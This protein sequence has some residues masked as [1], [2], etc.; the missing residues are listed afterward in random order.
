MQ[1]SDIP[2]EQIISHSSYVSALAS[3]SRT[4]SLLSSS[5][6]HR[7]PSHL[8][9]HLDAPPLVP[10]RRP[11]L[12]PAS[13]RRPVVGCCAP[14]VLRCRGPGQVVKHGAISARRTTGPAAR[15]VPTLFVEWRRS[16][17]ARS[18]PHTAETKPRTRAPVDRVVWYGGVELLRKGQQARGV[19]VLRGVVCCGVCG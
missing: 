19:K 15:A 3:H 5:S 6:P 16:G 9:Y 12:S 11:H 2:P 7:S 14:V 18:P 1:S 8:S 4:S 13:L 10:P 17:D